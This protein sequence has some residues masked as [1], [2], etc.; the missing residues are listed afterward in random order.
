MGPSSICL[1]LPWPGMAWKPFDRTSYRGQ[2]LVERIVST[3]RVSRMRKVSWKGWR[4]GL[5]S[6]GL[7][8]ERKES[9][10]ERWASN[11]TRY[12]GMVG[13][14]CTGT[15]TAGHP[16]FGARLLYLFDA[17]LPG[18]CSRLRPAHMHLLGGGRRGGSVK[19]GKAAPHSSVQRS[20]RGPRE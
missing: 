4:G 16:F 8:P 12:L 9:S 7:R 13:C 1:A 17:A 15:V 20:G 18:A 19:V 2:L 11:P 6:Q 14:G 10:F 3:A 5:L